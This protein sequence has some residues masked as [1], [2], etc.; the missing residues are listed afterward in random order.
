MD[1]DDLT[2]EELLT[3]LYELRDNW[4][5]NNHLAGV[6]Y[7]GEKHNRITAALQKNHTVKAKIERNSDPAY[8][9]TPFMVYI[10]NSY[11]T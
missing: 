2:E 9:T 5:R 6:Y 7:E 1:Y 8:S 4:N 11:S 10:D 3:K